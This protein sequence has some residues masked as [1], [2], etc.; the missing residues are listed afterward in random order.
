MLHKLRLALLKRDGVDDAL[1]LHALQSRTDDLPVGRV[2]HHGHSGNLRLGGNHIEEG[3]HLLTGIEQA[4]VH[5]DIDHECPVFHLLTGDGQSLVVVLFLNQ[6]QEL[7]RTSH[8]TTLSDIH[9]LH[10]RRHIQEFEPGE[11]HRLRFR[12][13]HMGLLAYHQWLVKADELIRRATATTDDVH[14]S[15]V[16]NLPHLR[17]HRLWRL[18]VEP[19]RVGQ[20]GIGITA[21]IIRC[22]SG[23]FTQIG[24]HLGGSKRAVQ[25][26]GEDRIGAHRGQ[27]GVKRLS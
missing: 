10:F 1:A 17:S 5:I 20:S 19:H 21:N 14:Q 3:G 6:P 22:L 9:K 13:R 12:C 7:P 23:Q 25:A 4:V 26:H 24:F 2:D 18:I 16:H 27:E 11:P 15:L 8:V